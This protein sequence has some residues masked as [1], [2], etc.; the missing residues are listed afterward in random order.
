MEIS[1]ADRSSHRTSK[2]QLDR[3]RL[4]DFDPRP[5]IEF[6][7]VNLP[8]SIT[9]TSPPGQRL[10]SRRCGWSL[11][12][13]ADAEMRHVRDSFGAVV[14]A[15]FRRGFLAGIH[16]RDS[17]AA[18]MMRRPLGDVVNLSRDDDP[19]VVPCVVPGDL[20]ARDAA[21]TA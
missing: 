2:K 6:H 9:S 10:P 12:E 18:G 16:S 20:F 19:A 5:W 4:L 17:G 13:L 8:G 3:P 1:E 21:R 14:V 15:E 11:D 7:A